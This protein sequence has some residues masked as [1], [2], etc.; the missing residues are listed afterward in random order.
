MNDD[1]ITMFL[2][3]CGRLALPES[4][5]KFYITQVVMAIGELHSQNL[6]HG[7]INLKKVMLSSDGF[8]KLI[9][10]GLLKILE[11]RCTNTIE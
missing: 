7:D 9:D 5:V 2:I 4:L 8:V 6:I 1:I 10:Y 11:N 3:D